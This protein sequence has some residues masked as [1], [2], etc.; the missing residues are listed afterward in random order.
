MRYARSTS[1]TA[2]VG[3]N[4]VEVMVFPVVKQ[5]AIGSGING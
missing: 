1:G 4:D 2:P 5:E 3:G